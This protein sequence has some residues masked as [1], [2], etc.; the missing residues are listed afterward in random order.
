MIARLVQ[1]LSRWAVI[2]VSLS[3]L[4]FT[5]AGTTGMG[6]LRA[7]VIAFSSNLL[8]TMLAVDPRL[9]RE[10]E[11]PGEEVI[12]S[13]LR[14]FAGFLFLLTAASAAFFV[15]RSGTLL[16]SAI[17]RRFALAIFV[18]SSS[19][20]TWAMI[21]NPFFSPVIRLQNEIAHRLVDSGPY[22]FVRHPGYLAMCISVCASALAIGSLLA[23]IPAASFVLVIYR[24]VR[25][26]DSFLRMNLP[27][28]NLY[29]Q[30]VAAGFPFVRST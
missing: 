12:P 25:L 14:F 29:A 10:R 20:Q 11:R 23:L 26:E 2:S 15:G 18:A 17:T 24:R 21:A 9:T 27:G 3:A 19:I 7:Y 16:V 8:I 1:K 28:Y 6:S 22:R 4:L 30:R 5:A 13:Q